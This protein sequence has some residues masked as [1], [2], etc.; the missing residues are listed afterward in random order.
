MAAALPHLDEFVEGHSVAALDDLADQDR[1][2]EIVRELLDDLDRWRRAGR[3]VAMARVV[4]IEGSGPAAARRGD[5]GGRRRRG[6]RLGVGRLRR[7][8]G[9]RG[10]PRGHATRRAG[11]S[12][13]SATPTTRRSPSGLTCGGTIHLFVEAV[14]DGEGIDAALAAALRAS[15]RWPWPPSSTDRPGRSGRSC[16]CTPAATRS[17]TLGDADLDRVVAR[18]AAGEL[19]AGT[20][21][22]RHYGP[23]GEARQDDVAVFVETVRAAAPHGR[24]RRR[25]LHRRPGAGGEG[26]RLPRHRVRRPAR[27]SPPKRRFPLADEVVVDWPN[28][29]LERVGARAHRHATR[30]ACSP[31][32]TSSTCP[33]IVGAL[34][35]GVGYIGAMGSRRTHAERVERLREAGV[36]DD[37]LARVHAPIGLDLGAR[38]PEETAVA[39]CAEIIATRTGRLDPRS[40]R[41]T[42]GPI[43][44]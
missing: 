25:R 39:I 16:S 7:G 13:R 6:G 3:R 26:A 44:R 33:P 11:V 17:A 18:D 5:G 8:R 20:T 35:T 24:L 43:H 42:D 1:R 14:D 40:L 32:T 10:G 41:E 23:H 38:T 15:S 19:A 34:A 27:C 2:V 36:D 31:T 30:C 37:G 12:A 28:R 21:G 29:L 9:R 4:D 22:V